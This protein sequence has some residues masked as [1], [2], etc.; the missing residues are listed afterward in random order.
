MCYTAD[1]SVLNSCRRA[2]GAAYQHGNRRGCLRGTREMV[3]NE[4]ELWTR[5]FRGSPV[6]WLNGL[7]GT[8]KSTVAQTVSERVFADGLLGA[9]FF[10]SRDFEDRSNLQLIF[11]TLA[12]Q[13]AHKYPTFR[14]A[15]VPL[16]RL[17]PDV[18]YESLYNQMA[19]LIVG[20][21]ELANI[22]TVIVIDALDECQDEE[23][24][25]AILS[26]LGRLVEQIPKV[27]FFVT[28]RPEPR[29]KTGFR[30]PLL[31]DATDVFV[32]HDVQP[33][34]INNDIRLFLKH[35]LSELA[36]R[37]GLDGWP[38]DDDLDMLC[39][40][41]AGLFVYAVATVKFLDN[42]AQLPKRR[43]EAIARLPES[44]DP[45][46]KTRFD[47][48]TTLDSLYTS[49]LEMAFGEQDHEVYTKVRSTIG[50]V[51]LLVN[52]LPPS[53]IAELIGLEHEEVILF[54]TLMESLLVLNEE[55][56]TQPVKTFHKSFPD[57]ITTPSCCT[58]T[59]F[60]ISPGYLHLDIVMGCL[61]LM[62]AGLKPN[63]LSLPNYALN[64]EI[65]DLK[66]RINDHISVALQ[67]A[68]QFWHSHLVKAEGDV[69]S[70]ISYIY[71]FLEEKF[72][73]WLEVASVLGATKEAITALKQLI[74]WLQQVCLSSL[75]DFLILIDIINQ[76]AQNDR[77]LDTA[78]DCFYF[79]TKFFEPIST[80]AIH[81]Y[82]SAL[83]LSPLLS[84][85][86]KLYYQKRLTPLPKVVVGTLDSWG[87]S[88]PF[89]GLKANSHYPYFT[90]SPC[91][92]FV[93]VLTSE[94]VEIHDSLT[95]ELLSTLT[96]SGASLHGTLA[97]SPDG[98]SLACFSHTALII[99]DIQTGGV[100]KEIICS[101]L[102]AVSLRWSLDGGS[103][104]AVFHLQD[105]TVVV[106]AF[107]IA[108]GTAFPLGMLQ[109]ITKL[110]LWAHNTSLQLM[111]MGWD[112]QTLSI[113]VFEVG[114]ILTKIESFHIHPG[115]GS[116]QIG[117][118]SERERNFIESFSPSTYHIAIL[119][120]SAPGPSQLLILD[121]RN[122]E[123]LLSQE[124]S[125]SSG[126]FSSDGSLFAASLDSIVYIWK[127]NSGCYS[128]WREFPGFHWNLALAQFSP[129][130]QS[131]LAGSPHIF[132]LLHL[133][134]LPVTFHTK[135]QVKHTTLSCCG[136][137]MV[138]GD[139]ENST[140]TITNPPSGTP[141]HFIDTGIYIGSLGLT[142]NILV[143]LD[144]QM[145]V[146]WCLTEEGAVDGVF[147]KRR[148]NRS[149]SIWAVPLSPAGGD[150]GSLV[151]INDLR[152]LVRDKTVVITLGGE[153]IHSYHS[154]TGEV[155]ESTQV[156]QLQHKHQYTCWDLQAGQHYPYC[157]RLG[158]P[159]T[160][161]E[162]NWPISQITLQAGWVK[163]PEGKHRLWIP[164]E[165]K[166]TPHFATCSWFY[167]ITAL[168]FAFPW[169]PNDTIIMF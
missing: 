60:Y 63:L 8:G 88:M 7:A 27:K 25:S 116:N 73:A 123:C 80:S 21:L 51:I 110:S 12:F 166:D 36:R 131:I 47:S 147:G 81:I 18:A 74:L 62:N 104:G 148:A 33:S 127:Y 113:N 5:D 38:N 164:P 10:C 24:S 53:A 31:K 158:E 146:G 59:R 35:E 89:F 1:L 130:S 142:G 100:T 91:G 69:T 39:R 150:L 141:C 114:S 109:S 105:S 82:H 161:P 112:T 144:H 17:N 84:I 93:A 6:F 108:L 50:T 94:A 23:T 90:W 99:W 155:L 55:D 28:G 106:C 169:C 72:L 160:T 48:K 136:T 129:T 54:L 2:A 45:V 154:G 70:V 37:R 85:V 30:L 86:R 115:T 15:L 57:F 122:S 40:R 117:I 102:N 153:V 128:L 159:S 140:L 163:D 87:Q 26:V 126:R 83:E 125:Y 119:K 92:Q 149:D 168:S 16:L 65:E 13:L 165:W 71:I 3:L 107:D 97:Y 133:D 52:P 61:G 64:S 118:S 67:Y 34:L 29:I 66:T 167:N 44:T 139:P 138:T 137:Y 42:K 152:F 95:F 143:V 9:S 134:V 151:N 157:H 68:C 20:P 132:Q 43:L 162:D 111:T 135:H 98:H 103:I 75:Q 96:K 79:A 77:L 22:P 78:R 56:P 58:D 41:A 46:G 145:I 11:P 4:I 49:I 101:N 19:K 14:S 120:L 121:I 124:G 76:I 32:L 156:L